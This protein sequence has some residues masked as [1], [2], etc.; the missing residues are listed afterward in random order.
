MLSTRKDASRQEK[1][2]PIETWGYMVF[3]V[4]L[5]CICFG[6]FDEK[7]KEIWQGNFPSSF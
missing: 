4:V 2:S 1:K 5:S 3:S 6:K 7:F